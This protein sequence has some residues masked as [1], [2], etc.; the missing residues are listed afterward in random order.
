MCV[1][2]YM[3]QRM[4]FPFAFCAYLPECVFNLEKVFTSLHYNVP[5]AAAASFLTVYE[6]ITR[7]LG[8][9]SSHH[10]QGVLYMRACE[11]SF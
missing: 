4:K 1:R 11:L 8:L 2:A 10:F 7:R 6:L 9:V 5:A 3:Q